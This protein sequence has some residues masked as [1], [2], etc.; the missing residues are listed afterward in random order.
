MQSH[1]ASTVPSRA[2]K[3]TY[4]FQNYRHK[5]KSESHLAVYFNYFHLASYTLS[6]A[7]KAR[8]TLSID[9]HND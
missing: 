6:K 4:S 9:S 8:K 1:H 5:T 7:C 3:H 2:A